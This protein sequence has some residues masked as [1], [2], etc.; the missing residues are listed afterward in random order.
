MVAARAELNVVM[1]ANLRHVAIHR[2]RQ[3][4]RDIAQVVNRQAEI[5]PRA[6]QGSMTQEV[7]D[8]FDRQAGPQ[9][10]HRIRVPHA[11]GPLER[12][13]QA[14]SLRPGLEGLGDRRP[15][16]DARRRARQ[17]RNNSRKARGGAPRYG[18]PCRRTFKTERP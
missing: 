7:P 16:E 8:R 15:L 12:N 13:G 5:H 2:G 10:V 18:T 14:A 6:F 4:Q 9:E 1:D 17:R 11:V 3:G